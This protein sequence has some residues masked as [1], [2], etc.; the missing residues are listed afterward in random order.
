M[1]LP[2][3]LMFQTAPAFNAEEE[4]IVVARQLRLIRVDLK[5]DKHKQGMTLQRCRIVRGSGR[6]D[7]DA[8][9]CD[10]AQQCVADGVA[11]RNALKSCVEDKST[12]RINAVLA[13]RRA[14]R[15]G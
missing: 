6:A 3:L 10:V 13:A 7:L 2:I 9:P 11:T 15:G 5:T 1:L 14:A 4:I 12:D 8:I